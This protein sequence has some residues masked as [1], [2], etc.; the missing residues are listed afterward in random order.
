[1]LQYTP[2]EQ[3]SSQLNNTNNLVQQDS[4]KNYV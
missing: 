3:N 1:M 4:L 2:K